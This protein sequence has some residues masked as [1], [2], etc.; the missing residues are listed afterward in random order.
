MPVRTFLDAGVLIAGARG[1]DAERE[2]ALEI[3]AD[4]ERRFIASS[5]LYL[6][7]APK[8]TFHKRRVEAAFYDRFFLDAQWAR[9]LERIDEIARSEA[10][11]YG[12]GAMDALHLAAAH[13]GGAAELITTE[14]PSKPIHRS[15]LVE[16]V[17]LYQRR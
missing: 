4:P 13:A 3:L 2:R 10:E 11:K 15:H 14:K 12:L 6:E 8:A 1:E 16:V 9:D 7:V 17:Y 5:Y